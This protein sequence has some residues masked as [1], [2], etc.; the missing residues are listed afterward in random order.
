M[1]ISEALVIA[2]AILPVVLNLIS[3]VLRLSGKARASAIVDA[4]SPIALNA[5]VKA[6][7]KKPAVV[8]AA[9]AQATP[10]IVI[11]LPAT[12]PADGGAQPKDTEVTP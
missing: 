3:T 8:Q 9:D 11:G 4:V 1:T 12:P 2:G 10:I 5:L 7:A 6:S